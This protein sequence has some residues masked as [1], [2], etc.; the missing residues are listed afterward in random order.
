MSED[1]RASDTLDG[2]VT[3]LEVNVSTI[4]GSVDHIS[5]QMDSLSMMISDGKRTPWGVLASWMTVLLVIGGMFAAVY[6]RDSQTVNDRLT[7]MDSRIEIFSKR[8][9]DDMK[10]QMQYYRGKQ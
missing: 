9:W 4:L 7:R 2:R 10:D 3:A 6:M 1:R 8:Q 5:K